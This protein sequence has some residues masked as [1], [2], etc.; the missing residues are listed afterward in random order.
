MC[1]KQKTDAKLYW[2]YVARPEYWRAAEVT[3]V[4]SV[5]QLPHVR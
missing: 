3:S 2:V 1:P 5:Q 4:R